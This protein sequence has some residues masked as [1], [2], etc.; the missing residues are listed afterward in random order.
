MVNYR[1]VDTERYPELLWFSQNL[2][3]LREA[4]DLSQSD[5]ASRAGL[6]QPFLS[7]L[8][9]LKANPTLEVISAIAKAT[10]LTAAA[11]VSPPPIDPF[12]DAND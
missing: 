8:E 5:F 12:P 9:N 2:K 1:D 7:A 11:L 3:D 6:S 10:G 4:L